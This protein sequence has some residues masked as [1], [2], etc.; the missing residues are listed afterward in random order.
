MFTLTA[1][2]F[3]RAFILAYHLEFQPTGHQQQQLVA[4]SYVGET[5]KIGLVGRYSLEET[6]CHI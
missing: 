3:S 1:S 4:D 6:H 2:D 5:V